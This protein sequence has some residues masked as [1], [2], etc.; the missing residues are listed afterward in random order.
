MIVLSSDDSTDDLDEPSYIPEDTA[1]PSTGGG[2]N[3]LPSGSDLPWSDDG[4]HPASSDDGSEIGASFPV[5]N[6]RPDQ[7]PPAATR[8]WSFDRSNYS[9]TSALDDDGPCD[10]DAAP[11]PPATGSPN[12]PTKDDAIPSSEDF[13]PPGQSEMDANGDGDRGPLYAANGQN[14]S[15][16]QRRTPASAKIYSDPAVKGMTPEQSWNYYENWVKGR[17]KIYNANKDFLDRHPFQTPYNSPAAVARDN[18]HVKLDPEAEKVWR[19]IFLDDGTTKPGQPTHN[20]GECA[21]LPINLA[22]VPSQSKDWRMGPRVMDPNTNIAPGTAIATFDEKIGQ[23]S[24]NTSAHDGHAAIF[25][26]KDGDTLWVL[27]QWNQGHEGGGPP[28]GG[29]PHLRPIQVA[30][31]PPSPNQRDYSNVANYFHIIQTKR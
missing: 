7:P 12:P 19:Q 29:L 15:G 20:L 25:I 6:A 4:N 9:Q 10:V 24:L 8:Q 3:I 23:Y 28:W 31:E 27:E 11:Q 18:P 26:K 2:L 13:P 17:M 21:S 14:S 22:G 5:Q 1:I 16:N 30:P